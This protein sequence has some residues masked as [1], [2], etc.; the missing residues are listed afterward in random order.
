MTFDDETIQGGVRS[1]LT[2]ANLELLVRQYEQK[3]DQLDKS[4]YINSINYRWRGPLNRF[5]SVRYDDK[6]FHHNQR[7]NCNHKCIC[8]S[9]MCDFERVCDCCIECSCLDSDICSYNTDTQIDFVKNS[10][11]APLIYDNITIDIEVKNRMPIDPIN[12][13]YGL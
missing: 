11:P 4:P 12:D 1:E 2:Q 5:F 13:P 6:F 10:C 9:R 8:G 7:L 3:I